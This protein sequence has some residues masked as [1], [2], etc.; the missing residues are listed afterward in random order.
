MIYLFSYRIPRIALADAPFLKGEYIT[1][2]HFTEHQ[3]GMFISPLHRRSTLH[4][5]SKTQVDK[6]HIHCIWAFCRT[7]KAKIKSVNRIKVLYKL[8]LTSPSLFFTHL[9]S[10]NEVQIVSKLIPCNTHRY[11]RMVTQSHTNLSFNYHGK[12]RFFLY[13]CIFYLLF[14]VVVYFTRFYLD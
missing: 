12:T 1:D 10:W 8:H 13:I 9:T 2:N 3:H 11:W 4:I 6:Q 7:C 5:K 14:F